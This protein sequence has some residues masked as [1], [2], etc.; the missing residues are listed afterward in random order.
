V[1]SLLS[2]FANNYPKL[3]IGQRV[4]DKV[5]KCRL[6]RFTLKKTR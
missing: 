2:I 4:I 1:E 6:D 3:L 5:V